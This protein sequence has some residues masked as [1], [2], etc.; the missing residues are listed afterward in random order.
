MKSWSTAQEIK[1]QIN[2]KEGIR[3]S[4]MEKQTRIWATESH[5]QA[6][7][8]VAIFTNN[9]SFPLVCILIKIY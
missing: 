4:A 5:T 2:Q 9:S 8:Y 3:F 6:N 7:N 1:D